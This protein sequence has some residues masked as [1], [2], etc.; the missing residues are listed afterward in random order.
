[1]ADLPILFIGNPN[2]SSWSLRPWLCLR[3]A[4]IEFEERIISLAQPGYGKQEIAELLAVAPNGRVPALH[5]GALRLWDSL[6]IAEWAAEQCRPGV[7]WPRDAD[8]RALARS[9]TA[10]MHS[11]FPDLRDELPMNIERR[12]V[13]SELSNGARRDIKRVKELWSG[14]RAL[15]ADHGP[16]LFGERSIADAFFAPV[17][18]R[19]RTYG[20]KLPALVQAWCN[21]IFGDAD[22]RAWEAKPITDRFPFIDE[23]YSSD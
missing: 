21:E 1:M 11:S 17:A 12:C 7:L 15:H 2:Y 19:F 20:V 16:W 13:A 4:G 23:I 6:A 5:V 18:T 22:F 8:L 14:L 9:A 10:E 3:W